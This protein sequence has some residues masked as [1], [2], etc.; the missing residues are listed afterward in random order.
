MGHK[1]DAGSSDCWSRRQGRSAAAR[2]LD[3]HDL[4]ARKL[5]ILDELTVGY[6]MFSR[7]LLSR[8]FRQANKVKLS[9]GSTAQPLSSKRNVGRCTLRGPA[10]IV[11]TGIDVSK[12]APRLRDGRHLRART[13]HRADSCSSKV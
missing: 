2:V 12:V 11:A 6:L 9:Y 10:L 7:R 8:G 3:P 5:A 4:I 1:A 13:D